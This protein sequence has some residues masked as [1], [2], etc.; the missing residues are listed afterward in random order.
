MN[1]RIQKQ[2]TTV[3]LRDLWKWISYDFLMQ[4]IYKI[5][6]HG[7]QFAH[8]LGEQHLY[9]KNTQSKFITVTAYSIPTHTPCTY[10][11]WVHCRM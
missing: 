2:L 11:T 8:S 5:W 6:S 1:G 3:K 10:D 9:N 7:P 4:W